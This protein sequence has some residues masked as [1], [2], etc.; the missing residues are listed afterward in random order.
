MR[1]VYLS[2]TVKYKNKKCLAGT[3]IEVDEKDLDS[4]KKAGAFL[5]AEKKEAENKET[6]KKEAENKETNKKGKEKITVKK[7]KSAEVV[8]KEEK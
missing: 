7:E 2:R 5:V 1:R 4:L 6:N 3:T 8:V